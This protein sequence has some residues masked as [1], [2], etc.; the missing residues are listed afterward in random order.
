M[1]EDNVR[2][3]RESWDAEAHEWVERGRRDW[4]RTG[5]VR[6]SPRPA[7]SRRGCSSGGELIFLGHSN[8]SMLRSPRTTNRPARPW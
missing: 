3:N 2:A 1:S 6:S 5:S 4:A 7:R 8:L